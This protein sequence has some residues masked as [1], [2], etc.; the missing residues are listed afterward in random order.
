MWIAL[1]N[2]YKLQNLLRRKERMVDEGKE[3]ETESFS[4]K[5]RFICYLNKNNRFM[6]FTSY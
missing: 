6:C 4:V 2:Q 1:R 3:E 5:E